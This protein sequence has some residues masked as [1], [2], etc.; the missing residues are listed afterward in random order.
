MAKVVYVNGTL[1]SDGNSGLTAALAKATLVGAS[2]ARSVTAA[3]D[4]VSI[5][6]G[7]YLEADVTWGSA[8]DD[9]VVYMPDGSGLVIVDFANRATAGQHWLLNRGVV[10]IGTQFRN[11]GTSTYCVTSHASLISSFVNCVFYQKAGGANTGHGITRGYVTNC[12]FRNLNIATLTPEYIYNSYIVSCTTSISGSTARD[13][14]ALAGNT[15]INGINISTGA[16]PGFRDV[17]NDDFRLSQTTYADF[18]TF[19][20]GGRYGGKI[21]ASGTPGPYYN[22]S[23]APTRIISPDPT[24][25]TGTWPAWEN[26]SSYVAEGVLGVVIED[27][28]TNELV[29]DLNSTP[30]ATDGRLRSGVL[31][32]PTGKAFNFTSSAIDR[33][34]D[35]PGGG[36][37][38]V[39]TTLP[40]HYEYRYSNS[41]FAIG[42]ALPAWI[43]TQ[44]SDG[45]NIVAKYVQ[46]R[47]T[48]RTDHTNA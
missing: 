15:E 45:L 26:D 22:A 13:Y 1:G 6:G 46:F 18:Q 32:A 36:R 27:P 16:N 10:F 25:T 48:L 44:Q 40:T 33:F 30:T 28:T 35:G 31:I 20:V 39:N 14:N 43:Q 38:D 2:G 5:A 34:E 7:T 8:N 3:G 41:S 47:V 24:P 23:F 9:G 37:L 11:P 4:R 29:L 12:S 17:A 21:G 19:M 42:D